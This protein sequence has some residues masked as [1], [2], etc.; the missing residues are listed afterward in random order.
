MPWY[1]EDVVTMQ[2]NIMIRR[3]APHGQLRQYKGSQFGEINVGMLLF[4]CLILLMMRV[5]RVECLIVT[6]EETGDVSPCN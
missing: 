1:V 6:M 5:D 4:E 3:M 2:E